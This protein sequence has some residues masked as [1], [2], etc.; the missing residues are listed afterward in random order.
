MTEPAQNAPDATSHRREASEAWVYEEPAA[1]TW[2]DWLSPLLVGALLLAGA[3]GVG[4]LWTGG[5]LAANGMTGMAGQSP[6]STL[7]VVAGFAHGQPV[8]FVHTEASDS[9]VASMLTSMMGSPVLVVPSLADM[10]DTA[11]ADVYVF[12]NGVQPDGP[13]GPFGFQPDVFDSVPGDPAYSPLRRLNLVTWQD[14][15]AVRLLRSAE[16]VEAAEAAG[17]VSIEATSA[18]VNMPI[19]RWPGGSR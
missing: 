10:P 2:R 18:V 15:S 1:R 19:T 4:W 7:P 12:R 17:Q 9:A 14:P 3:L 16:E 11:L 5:R 6:G 8:N 13:R